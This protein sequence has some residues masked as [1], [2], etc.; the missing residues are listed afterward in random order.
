M[1]LL[2][3]LTRLHQ[4]QASKQPV[5]L[6]VARRELAHGQGKHRRACHSKAL[7]DAAVGPSGCRHRTVSRSERGAVLKDS[8]VHRIQIHGNAVSGDSGIDCI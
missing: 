7:P 2:V 8:N 5:W 1:R 3:K 6:A 4:A